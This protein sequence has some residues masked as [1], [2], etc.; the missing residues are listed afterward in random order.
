VF[1]GIIQAVGSL[2][3]VERRG[4]SAWLGVGC[5]FA[6]L[7]LGESVAVDGVCLTVVRVI[8]GGFTAD[9]SVETLARTTLGERSVGAR[10]NLERALALG[11]RMGGHIVSGHVDGVGELARREQ[12]ESSERV[13]FR[14]PREVL[15][16]VAE[17]GSVAIDGV[18]LTVNA[19][20]AEGFEVM[21]VPFT[22]GA[23]TLPERRAGDRVNLEVDVIARYVARA[24]TWEREAPDPGAAAAG[25]D[26]RWRALLD[27]FGK[28]Q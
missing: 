11:D 5:P 9:A 8:D 10:V 17:K 26:A 13:V 6:K 25:T 7:E 15:R 2:R 28:G 3:S 22:Q 24:L 21:L 27:G 12:V 14:A 23:T 1:T 16:Y 4:A 20:S 18:S 19:V